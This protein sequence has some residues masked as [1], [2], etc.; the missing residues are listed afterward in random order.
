[1]PRSHFLFIARN[2]LRSDEFGTLARIR[3]FDDGKD[4]V[5]VFQPYDLKGLQLDEKGVR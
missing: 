2:T 1:M 3:G 5:F 4:V